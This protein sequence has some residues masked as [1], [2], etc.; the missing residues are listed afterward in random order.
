MSLTFSGWKRQEIPLVEAETKEQNE[1][2]FS[3]SHILVDLPSNIE[4]VCTM[5]SQFEVL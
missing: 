2:T 3:V 5:T 1:R 4:I